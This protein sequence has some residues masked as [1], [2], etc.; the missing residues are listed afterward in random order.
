MNSHLESMSQII[1]SLHTDTCILFQAHIYYNLFLVDIHRMR[2]NCNKR[3]ILHHIPYQYR[4]L[5]PLFDRLYIF[6]FLTHLMSFQLVFL[7]GRSPVM[8]QTISSVRWW[9]MILPATISSLISSSRSS[10]SSGA[11]ERHLCRLTSSIILLVT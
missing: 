5:I 11:I 7:F 6:S 4:L 10:M 3:Y 1:S 9:N 2:Y 8:L